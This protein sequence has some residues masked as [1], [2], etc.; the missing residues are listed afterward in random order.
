MIYPLLHTKP[1]HDAFSSASRWEPA[2]GWRSGEDGDHVEA[3]ARVGS[4]GI[5]GR[6]RTGA[7][8]DG[9]DL[10][11]VNGKSSPPTRRRRG[12]RGRDP[13]QP[14][15]GGRHHGRDPPDGGRRHLHRRRR[16]R[17][18][19]P[20]ST[21]RTPTWARPPGVVLKLEG[22]DPALTGCAHS[23]RRPLRHVPADQWIYGTVGERVLSDPN[24]TRFTLDDVAPTRLVKLS[25]WTGH[26]VIFSTAA[27]R[28]I[29]IGD[30]EPDPPF[31]RYRRTQ[32]GTVDGRL[33]E[34]ADLRAH[35]RMAALVS[36]QAAVASLRA[37]RSRRSATASRRSRRWPYFPRPT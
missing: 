5:A 35:R 11:P 18:V 33:D 16:W 8:P 2:C 15:H 37:L 3:A 22:N 26:G 28:A 6:R 1:P 19:I 10:L 17:V 21:T 31:G 12:P 13:R 27:L 25:T 9:L 14:D 4:V 20:E 30:R 24:A 34:Y 32:D 7:Q 23:L 36:H 29:D